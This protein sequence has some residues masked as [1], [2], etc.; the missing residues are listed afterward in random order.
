MDYLTTVGVCSIYRDLGLVLTMIA[1]FSAGNPLVVEDARHFIGAEIVDQKEG[2][3][4]LDQLPTQHAATSE[5]QAW[6]AY[7]R[8]LAHGGDPV[9]GLLPVS[10]AWATMFGREPRELFDPCTAVSV[11]T[12]MLGEYARR[13]AA[14]K[15]DSRACVVRKYAE[16][17]HLTSF[18]ADVMSELRANRDLGDG[19]GHGHPIAVVDTDAIRDAPIDAPLEV[20]RPAALR[21][22]AQLAVPAL[23]K[24]PLLQRSKPMPR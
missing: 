14:E 21:G 12:A 18:A 1:R 11:G 23:S 10:P 3:D 9:V 16:A 17:I 4:E 24:P 20:E 5:E 7:K 6:R 15:H 2:A 13:C 8:M 22:A 19:H